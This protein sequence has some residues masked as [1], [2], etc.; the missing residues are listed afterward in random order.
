MSN[1][2]FAINKNKFNEGKKMQQVTN[3]D[4]SKVYHMKS[5][6][7]PNKRTEILR[8]LILDEKMQK[9]KYEGN[10]KI[11]LAYGIYFLTT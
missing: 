3:R 4:L 8:F 1:I 11:C 7:V 9:K 10:K 6:K 5:F 2:T